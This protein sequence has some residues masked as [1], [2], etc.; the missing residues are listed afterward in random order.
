MDLFECRF[1]QR[2]DRYSSVLVPRCH[3]PVKQNKAWKPLKPCL[4]AI[5]FCFFTGFY[6]RKRERQ[7]WLEV[8]ETISSLKLSGLMKVQELHCD[9]AVVPHH[10]AET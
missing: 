9:T 1:T 5:M 7:R 8:E 4:S 2:T 6:R 10:I 3:V